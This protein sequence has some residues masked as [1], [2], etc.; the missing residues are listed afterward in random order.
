MHLGLLRQV[1]RRSDAVLTYMPTYW[2]KDAI[3]TGN[4][5]SNIKF[6]GNQRPPRFAKA[7]GNVG[8]DKRA[9]YLA[10]PRLGAVGSVVG[11]VLCQERAIRACS[12]VGRVGC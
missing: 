4:I 3:C 6:Y 8:K 1:V 9:C 11:V 10:R 12:T 7:H 5:D 2:P